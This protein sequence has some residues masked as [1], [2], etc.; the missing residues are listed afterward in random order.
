MRRWTTQCSTAARAAGAC[1]GAAVK[2]SAATRGL[3]EP[4][5]TAR[6]PEQGKN[7]VASSRT[8]A[9]PG[10]LELRRKAPRYPG[11]APQMSSLPG[12][13][14]LHADRNNK[15]TEGRLR[16]V[17]R[18]QQII[19]STGR[20]QQSPNQWLKSAWCRRCLI[21]TCTCLQRLTT[22]RKCLQRYRALGQMCIQRHIKASEW[23]GRRASP[24]SPSC[25]NAARQQH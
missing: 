16:Q 24:S 8:G 14:E 4:T 7:C 6:V 12:R 1:L 17:Q 19:C 11:M 25:E 3:L 2:T 5:A 10:A 23:V 15:V 20:Q 18:H 9:P 13:M 22:T 21:N